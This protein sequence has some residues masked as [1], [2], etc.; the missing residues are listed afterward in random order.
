MVLLEK[1]TKNKE[2][3]LE[4]KTMTARNN[5]QEIFQKEETSQ[6]KMKNNIRVINWVIFQKIFF[7]LSP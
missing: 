6:T 7:S 2:M 5:Q 4:I 1:R 3:F